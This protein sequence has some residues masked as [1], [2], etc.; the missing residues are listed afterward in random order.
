MAGI[1]LLAAIFKGNERLIGK[2][3]RAPRK[4]SIQGARL[5]F[6]V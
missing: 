1:P 5:L 4:G 2:N 6:A 3:D